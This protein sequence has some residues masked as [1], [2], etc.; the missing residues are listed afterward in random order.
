MI[1]ENNLIDVLKDLKFSS[2][3]D[4]IYKKFFNKVNC[5]IEVDIA[6]RRIIYPEEIQI[7]A[8]TITNFESLENFVVLECVSYGF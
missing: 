6:N 1:N 4:N 7:T 5:S 3:S 2:V 8:R